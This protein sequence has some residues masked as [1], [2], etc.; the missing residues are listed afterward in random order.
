MFCQINQCYGQNNRKSFSIIFASR[1]FFRRNKYSVKKNEKAP[2]QHREYCCVSKIDPKPYVPN[3][4]CLCHLRSLQF[5][6]VF[7]E[8]INVKLETRYLPIIIYQ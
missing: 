2:R 3:L 8:Q 4:T 7:T 1:M 6:G 5:T